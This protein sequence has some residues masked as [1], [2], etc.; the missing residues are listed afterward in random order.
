MLVDDQAFQSGGAFGD[1]RGS[2]PRHLR[3]HTTPAITMR[4]RLFLPPAIPTRRG[5]TFLRT[6][7]CCLPH[8]HHGLLLA[9]GWLTAAGYRHNMAQ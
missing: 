3:A 7:A 9:L 1:G 2:S 5:Y 4:A 8:Q 6:A